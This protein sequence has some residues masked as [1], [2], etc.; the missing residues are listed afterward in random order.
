MSKEDYAKKRITTK[1]FHKRLGMC[2]KKLEEAKKCLM[3]GFTSQNHESRQHRNR[4]KDPLE[5][6]QSSKKK[7]TIGDVKKEMKIPD[8]ISEKIS[9]KISDKISHKISDKIPDMIPEKIPDKIPDKILDKIPDT[10]N[11]SSTN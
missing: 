3:D 9:D 4:R 8:K 10:E 2:A 6:G 11:P 7:I 5:E 1:E